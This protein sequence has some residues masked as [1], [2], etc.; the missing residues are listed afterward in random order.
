MIENYRASE[1]DDEKAGSLIEDFFNKRN[2]PEAKK[3]REEEMKSADK[4][5]HTTTGR[6]ISDLRN[7]MIFSCLRTDERLYKNYANSIKEHPEYQKYLQIY[8]YN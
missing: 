5:I 4:I 7:D 2:T 6:E 3:R 1:L 8:N